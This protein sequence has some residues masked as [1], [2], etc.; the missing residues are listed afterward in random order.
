MQQLTLELQALTA[1][2]AEEE[3]IFS[4]GI[5]HGDY[6]AGTVVRPVAGAPMT[7]FVFMELHL[8]SEVLEQRLSTETR[9]FMAAVWR[10]APA[11]QWSKKE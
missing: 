10:V 5:T 3:I 11:D 7:T 8:G 2:Q 6:W 9:Q 1:D 4:S